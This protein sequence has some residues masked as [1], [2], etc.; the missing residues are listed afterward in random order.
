MKTC[1]G[2]TKKRLGGDEVAYRKPNGKTTYD[3]FA[4]IKRVEEE[5]AAAKGIKIILVINEDYV[6]AIDDLRRVARET[7]KELKSPIMRFL[8]IEE[9]ARKNAK[10]AL[11]KPVHPTG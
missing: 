4:H 11:K 9:W 10:R 2:V 1:I 6:K 3:Q 7:T 8:Q 5:I